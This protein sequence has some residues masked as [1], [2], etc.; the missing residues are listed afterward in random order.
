[1]ASSSSST[2][3]LKLLIDSKRERVLFAEAS[4]AVV[5]FLFNLLRLPIGTVI[6]I[7]NKDQ[8]VRSLGNLYQSVENLDQTYMQP[9]QQKDL[10]LKPS[11]AISSSQISGLLPSIDGSSGNSSATAVFYRCPNHYGHITC[12]NR[13]RCP[14]YYCG[15][16]MDSKVSL[17][18]GIPKD[19]GGDKSG[20]VK[21]VVTYMVVDDLVIQPMS[22]IST[23][24]LLNKFNVTEMASL[25]EKVV[26]L[27]MNKGVNILK[28]SLQSKTVLTDVFL[29]NQTFT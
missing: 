5:D 26:V 19:S 27:D 28:A 14:D 9:N 4:K 29:K 15:R 7:L 25:Q 11:A 6:R 21:E 10:L 16:N 24:A 18:G 1:M 23:I 2:L 3:T 17:I 13:A 12:D 22:S 20:F 8:M